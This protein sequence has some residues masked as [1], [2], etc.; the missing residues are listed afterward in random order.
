MSFVRP[1]CGIALLAVP[2]VA[3][4]MLLAP[5]SMLPARAQAIQQARCPALP[6]PIV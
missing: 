2:A 4:F 3:A 1:F 5:A 6:N